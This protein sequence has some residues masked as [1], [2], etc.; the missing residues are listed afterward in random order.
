MP[1]SLVA[2]LQTLDCNI[3]EQTH[4]HTHT[5]TPELSGFELF[6]LK[7][8]GALKQKNMTLI[9]LMSNDDYKRT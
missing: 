7:C 4:T 3:D 6:G 9:T 1:F 2:L 8:T 5:H